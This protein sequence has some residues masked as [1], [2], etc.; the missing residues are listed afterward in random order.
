MARLARLVLPGLQHHVVMRAETGRVLFGIESDYRHFRD[1][2]VVAAQQFDV[3]I[4]AACLLPDHVHLVATPRTSDGLARFV[5][6]ACRRYARYK[7]MADLWQGRFRSCPLDPEHAIAAIGY[8]WQNPARLGL[9]SWPWMLGE[10][11]SSPPP[12]QLVEA[13]RSATRTGRPAGSAD[14]FARIEYETGRSV[15]PRKR[16]R[17]PR[18]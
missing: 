1:L 12:P 10:A 3:A 15:R 9:K 13:I 14:F 6:E 8:V 11:S 5:G 4:L 17:K 2:L 18:W 7:T 16:G